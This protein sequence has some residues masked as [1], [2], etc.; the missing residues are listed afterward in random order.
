MGER[1]SRTHGTVC[2]LL[3]LILLSL[4]LFCLRT[5]Q[6]ISWPWWA[7]FMPIFAGFAFLM[8]CFTWGFRQAIANHFFGKWY[9]MYAIT[10]IGAFLPI[11]L[12]LLLLVVRLDYTYIHM[13]VVMLPFW[14]WNC[15]TVVVAGVKIAD[16]YGEERWFSCGWYGHS[17]AQSSTVRT[18]WTV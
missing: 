12:F 15:V 6:T 1:H 11:M 18:E 4:I 2:C 9:E 8:F 5:T 13:A 3:V 16:G 17:A 10:W 14:I 7:V